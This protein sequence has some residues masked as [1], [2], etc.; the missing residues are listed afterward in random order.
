MLHGHRNKYLSFAQRNY[1]FSILFS[2]YPFLHRY[3]EGATRPWPPKGSEN[4]VCLP[5]RLAGSALAFLGVWMAK[6]VPTALICA[7]YCRYG[8]ENLFTFNIR[9]EFKIVL[10]NFW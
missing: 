8:D 6:L 9:I 7:Y 5:N 10:W 2:K 1:G 3:P 4:T